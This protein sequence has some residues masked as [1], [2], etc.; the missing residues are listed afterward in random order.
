M[1]AVGAPVPP[2]LVVSVLLMACLLGSRLSVS[3]AGS[4]RPDNA[5]EVLASF[6]G[7]RQFL[8]TKPEEPD[9]MVS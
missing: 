1:P 5:R 4:L 2:V 6:A 8:L 7:L 3:F 9:A